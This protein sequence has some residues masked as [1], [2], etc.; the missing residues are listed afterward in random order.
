M[1]PRGRCKVCST[2]RAT[3]F[4]VLRPRA[5]AVD[6]SHSDT[7]IDVS[8]P[9]YLEILFFFSL[10]WVNP[11]WTKKCP[12]APLNVKNPTIAYRYPNNAV[13][14]SSHRNPGER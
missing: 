2:L 11:S 1:D 4:G 8:V 10:N 14:I 5:R 9:S 12:R 3:L 7:R 6:I 13:S